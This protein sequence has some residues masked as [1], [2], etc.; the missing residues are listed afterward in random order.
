MQVGGHV[1]ALEEDPRQHD[2]IVV[3]VDGR[4]VAR[5]APSAARALGLVEGMPITEVLATALDE[6]TAFNAAARRAARRLNRRALS[7]AETA[8]DLERQGF[9]PHIVSR[10]IEHLEGLGVLDDDRLGRALIEEAQARRGA[11]PALLRR[12]LAQRQLDAPTITLL[13]ETMTPDDG[14]ADTARDLAIHRLAAMHDLDGTT[15]RRRLY[16]FLS[17]RGFEEDIV[18]DV[19]EELVREDA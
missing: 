7:C 2:Q 13:I 8:S 5:I 18:L 16:G 11:G 3:R 9:D 14:G 4:I 12:K 10:V 6:A 1:S 15:K 19:V 17:R